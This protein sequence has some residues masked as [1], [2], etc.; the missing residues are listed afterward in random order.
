MEILVV[1]VGDAFSEK[2]W[3]TNFLVRTPETLLAVDCP[4]SYFKALKSS[5][6]GVRVDDLDGLFL[7]HLHGDHVNGLEMTLAWR[8][9]VTQKR[10]PL[11][12][13]PEVAEVLWEGRLKA[14]LGTMYDGQNH[15]PMVLEDYAEVTVIPWG[16][17][18]VLLGGLTIE[19]RP[20]VHHIPTAALRLTYQKHTFGHSC[21][22]I[23]D[24]AL[25]EWLSASELFFHEAN[26]GPA[27]TPMARLE[28]LPSLIREKMRI[29]HYSDHIEV[30]EHP[31]VKFATEGQHF[32][33]R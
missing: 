20:T 11:F 33:L 8:K 1:G 12:T 9:F 32:D 28:E 19:T 26:F 23:Y 18:T 13:T 30:K 21:D 5:G 17:P 22:T 15:V 14:S 10:L 16:E 29:V 6:F 3:G 24:P 2:H 25:I 4:D 7:T 27:H 31:S